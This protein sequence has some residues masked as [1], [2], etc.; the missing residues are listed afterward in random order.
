MKLGI[1]GKLEHEIMPHD[2][3]YNM[4]AVT[5]IGTSL[6]GILAFKSKFLEMGMWEIFPPSPIPSRCGSLWP[7]GCFG[8]I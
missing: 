5:F 1:W 4:F 7:D 2:K 3:C 6:R 8:N